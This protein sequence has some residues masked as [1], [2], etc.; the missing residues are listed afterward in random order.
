MN[1]K[2]KIIYSKGYIITKDED[3]NDLI[4]AKECFE[5]PN[6]F[7]IIN[8]KITIGVS[9][10]KI[11]Q[12]I[13]INLTK[14]I[15]S[16]EPEIS[17]KENGP[18]LK[19][20]SRNNPINNENNDLYFNERI[21]KTE[22]SKRPFSILSLKDKSN[23]GNFKLTEENNKSNFLTLKPNKNKNIIDI[24]YKYKTFKELKKIFKDSIEREKYF[25]SKGTNDLIP[26]R[27]DINI[28]RKFVSQEKKLKFNQTIKS[29][30]EKYLKTLAKKCK[31]EE[32]E[33]LMNTI[34]E[35]TIKNKINEFVEKNKIL[36]ERFGNNYWL[37]TL[38]R[39][40]K[41]DFI[42]LNYVN[43]GDREREIWKRFVD[44]PD[45]EIELINDPYNQNNK[46]KI[47]FRMNEKL[48]DKIPNIKGIIEMKIEGK[49]LAKK[50]FKDITEIT[51]LNKNNCKFKLYKDPRENNKNNINNFTCK[52][53]YKLNSI[54]IN[55][56]KDMMNAQ[57]NI[58]KINFR[59]FSSNFSKKF[60]RNKNIK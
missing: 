48:R 8:P 4:E 58:K 5:E 42:R 35:Y 56:K 13:K 36:S 50:E 47:L 2:S 27:T 7:L 10:D 45:R 34:E 39:P 52:E 37:F 15:S 29:K 9:P 53:L 28:K 23:P 33:L 22:K 12:N 57:K 30:E 38:R 44:Y 21:I 19:L 46:N 59:H 40:N 55:D 17:K 3:E 1:I 16:F 60:I 51:E 18:N 32:N 6:K 49:N 54:K 31:K 24:H 11:K 25:K 43:V 14:N 20:F 41:N 26:L